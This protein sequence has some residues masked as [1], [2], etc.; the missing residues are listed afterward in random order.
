MFL[1]WKHWLPER[2]LRRKCGHKSGSASARAVK[3]AAS[4]K[5]KVPPTWRKLLTVNTPKPEMLPLLAAGMSHS[6]YAKVA[7][8]AN[9]AEEDP[10]TFGPIAEEMDHTGKVDPKTPENPAFLTLS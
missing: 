9:L 6:Q 1:P 2:Q 10:E 5:R 8:V 3:R 4:R 7:Y